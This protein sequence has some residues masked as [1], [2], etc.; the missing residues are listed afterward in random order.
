[1]T[2]DEPQYDV[3]VVGAGASRCSAARELARDH[4]VLVLEAG[5]VGAGASGH[6]AGFVSSFD[7]WAPSPDAVK[8]AI[9]SFRAFDGTRGFEFVDRLYVELLA[10]EA[11]V[12]DARGT[13]ANLLADEEYELAVLDAD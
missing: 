2:S 10:T 3:I 5:Q 13:Y 9:D 11:E 1:M 8:Y 6:A 7:E 12:E 4:D